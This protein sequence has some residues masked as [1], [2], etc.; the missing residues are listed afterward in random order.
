MATPAPR[1]DTASSS[2]AL[3]CFPLYTCQMPDHPRRFPRPWTV[4][5]TYTC[6]MVLDANGQKL[7]YVY[8]ESEPGQRSAAN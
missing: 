2:I 3:I 1:T 7:A 8:F 4:E 5:K 6:F